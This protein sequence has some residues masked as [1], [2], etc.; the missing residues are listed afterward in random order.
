MAL[1]ELLFN[2]KMRE[3]EGDI[4]CRISLTIHHHVEE[5]E[6]YTFDCQSCRRFIHLNL[7]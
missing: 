2:E 5:T 4:D 3:G 7:W 1:V 6:Q